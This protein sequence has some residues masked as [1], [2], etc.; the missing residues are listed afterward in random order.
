MSD[1]RRDSALGLQP[2]LP[3]TTGGEVGL[4]GAELGAGAQVGGYVVDELR[5]R[6][7]FA[8]VYR[9]RHAERGTP[10]ALKVLH[11]H[12]ATS[13]NMI[14]RF[15][16]EAETVARLRHP[17]IVELHE[18]GELSDG[19][20]WFVMEWLEGHNL[21]EELRARGPLALPEALAVME[22]LCAALSAA[23]A[24]GVVHRDLKG[25][26]VVAIPAGEWFAVKLVDFGI[27]KLLDDERPREEGLT[28][29]GARMGTPHHMA[30]EQILGQVVDAR[31]DVYALGVLLY[32]LVTGQLP[33]RAPTAIEIEEM[34]L[35]AP[36]PRASD[37]A[38]VPAAI[39]AVIERAMAK[40]RQK[41]HASV[42]ELVADLRRAA[43]GG[44][45]TPSWVEKL[46][47]SG[48]FRAR[49][50]PAI[51]VHVDVRADVPD[52][53]VD[54]ALLDDLEGVAAMARGEIEAAGL[55]TVVEGGNSFLA[56]LVL[57]TSEP[58]ARELRARVVGAALQLAYHVAA[59]EHAHPSVHAAIVL[60]VA[61]IS[62]VVV[63]DQPQFVGGD[64]LALGDWT[65]GHPGDAVTASEAVLAGLDD[66][67]EIGEPGARAFR[68]VIAARR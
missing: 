53:E 23:H 38:P 6:G 13:A 41:R 60:H 1:D 51:G 19:R 25:S 2:T 57:P 5:S 31:T 47:P 4:Y 45:S 64:L 37:V 44:A 3:G 68:K 42:N 61:S 16:Q 43:T 40:D 22:D 29:T 11:A 66:R 56:V 27:A 36:P 34:H 10:A 46:R 63:D 17:N 62:A 15:R 28:S 30:P 65:A 24:V 26:N 49:S 59:R 39:D 9:V 18:V 35:W 54:D 50:A 55:R 67:F 20:P 33:F 52:E 32:Q 48:R 12:L 14:K 21:D 58:A 7:G 8:T